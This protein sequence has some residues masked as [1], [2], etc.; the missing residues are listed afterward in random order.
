LLW[1]PYGIGQAIIFLPCA[2]YL[3]YLFFSSPILSGRRLDVY[4]TSTHGV[5][6]VRIYNAGMKCV[7]CGSLLIQDAKMTQKLASAHHRTTLS[8]CIF[9]TEARIDNRKKFLKSNMSS[10]CLH[11]MANFGP[12]TAEIGSGV[13]GTQANFNGFRVLPSLLQRRRSPEANQTSHDVWPSP[14]AGALVP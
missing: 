9:A 6:L 14:W 4:H 11:N 13:W 8:G 5:D 12:L 10:I 2:F 1:P 3:L 7:A